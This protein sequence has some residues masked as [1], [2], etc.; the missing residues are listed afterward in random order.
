M[1]YICTIILIMYGLAFTS[2]I[3]TNYSAIL[4]LQL[5]QEK[6]GN[7]LVSITMGNFKWDF[8]SCCR[9]FE[10]EFY[11]YYK[12]VY[13]ENIFSIFFNNNMHYR[14]IFSLTF[15]HLKKI[16]YSLMSKYYKN[17]NNHNSINSY[18]KIYK[19]LNS[20]LPQY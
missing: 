4:F 3:S 2:L 1:Q 8:T 17:H 14:H 19:K 10:F 20:N 7:I 18:R 6:A 13:V 16:N 9:T 12:R 5:I 11:L 15:D